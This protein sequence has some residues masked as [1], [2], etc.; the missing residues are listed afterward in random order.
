MVWDVRWH[1]T[2]HAPECISLSAT[3]TAESLAS[4]AAEAREIGATVVDGVLDVRDA[5][6]LGGFFDI[7][8]HESST[9]GSTVSMSS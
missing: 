8:D 3:A 5:D 7:V 2:S 4:T 6:A 9:A 1:W